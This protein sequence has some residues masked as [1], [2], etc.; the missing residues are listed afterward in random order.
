MNQ[1]AINIVE[2]VSLWY[3]GASFGYIPRSGI[4]GTSGKTIYNFLRNRQIDFQSSCTSV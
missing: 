1:V 3:D 2:H 4:A